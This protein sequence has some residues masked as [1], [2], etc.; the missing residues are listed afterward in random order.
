MLT[1]FKTVKQSI[2]R[3]HHFEVMLLDGSLEKFGKQ[4]ALGYK[5]E[6][7]KLERSSFSISRL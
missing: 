2:K 7:E 3:L 1:N 6:I 4:E 5:R